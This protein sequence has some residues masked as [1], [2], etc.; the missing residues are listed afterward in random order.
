MFKPLPI[1]VKCGKETRCSKNE[2]AVTN[3]ILVW[4]GDKYQ[5]PTCGFEV[6]G[7]FGTPSDL[8]N[9][10]GWAKKLLEEAKRENMFVEVDNL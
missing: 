1:C 9:P 10:S 3:S 7:G 8:N 5:C 6:V 2:F 4:S